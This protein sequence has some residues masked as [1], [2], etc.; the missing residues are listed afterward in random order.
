MSLVLILIPA[1]LSTSLLMNEA[2]RESLQLC[3]FFTLET[4]S[5]EVNLVP[6]SCSQ[7]AGFVFSV[8]SFVSVVETITTD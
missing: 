3:L 7:N 1:A 4:D 8:A 5:Q 2:V 6:G